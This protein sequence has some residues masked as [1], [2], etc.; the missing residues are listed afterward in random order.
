MAHGER[1]DRAQQ[2]QEWQLER[3]NIDENPAWF[4]WDMWEHSLGWLREQ[5]VAEVETRTGS[6]F[7][8]V[9]EIETATVAT[10]G[11]T[12]SG[13]AIEWGDGPFSQPSLVI[14]GGG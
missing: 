1:I 13:V 9:F 3:I 4:L 5:V 12:P 10:T 2:V 8:W 11:E 14:G 7:Q 6:I